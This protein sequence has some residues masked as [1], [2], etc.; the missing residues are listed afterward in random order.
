L[1][2]TKQTIDVEYRIEGIKGAVVHGVDKVVKV[3]PGKIVPITALVK[4]EQDRLTSKLMPIT[5]KA[6]VISQPDIS[7]DYQS[8]FISPE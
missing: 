4:V 8:M 6:H 5:F 3:A 2:K 7:I 1:N